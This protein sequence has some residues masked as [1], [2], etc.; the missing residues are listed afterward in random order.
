[1]ILLYH[2]VHPTMK[3]EWW[4]T[5]DTFYR[6]MLDLQDKRVVY[7]D[8]YDPRDPSQAVIT[9][10]GV[11][12]NVLEYAVP[13]MEKFGYP[14]ELFV[15]GDY[16]GRDNAF[17]S[18]EPLADFA[19][20]EELA[21][22][23]RRGGRIQWHTRS[24]PRV[25]QVLDLD[26]LRHE[27]E[28][29]PEVGALD[30]NGCRWFA[31]PHGEFSAEAVSLVRE[32]F[33]GALSCIQGDDSDIYQWNRL[34]VKEPTKITTRRISVIIPSYNYGPFLAEAVESVLRQT[35]SVDEIL[36]SDDASTDNTF[37]IA[38]HFQEQHPD[39]IRLNRNEKNL[40]IVDHFNRAVSLTSGDYITFLGAD[41][42]FRSDY[43]EHSCRALD[44]NPRAG[45]A[46]TDLCLFGSRASQVFSEFSR[47]FAGH[48]LLEKLFVVSF[49][50]FDEAARQLL[51]SGRNFIH[52]SSL[53]RRRAFE[54]VGGY[55]K[56]DDG[57]ED[58]GLFR[59]MIAA[60]WH[61]V[62]VAHPV[63]EYRQH[64]REQTNAALNSYLEL[65]YY[66]KKSQRLQD[67]VTQ[68]DEKLARLEKK[69]E[70]A[71]QKLKRAEDELR[72]IKRSVAWKLSKPARLVEGI[73]RQ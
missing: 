5:V 45:V 72:R 61:A 16:I 51:L 55:E 56:R 70:K 47:H 27:L 62:R 35:R 69:I 33:V 8:D 34:T 40:G 44:R 65:Q 19:S 60:D 52:G 14:F 24:H 50:D 29:P 59:R 15:T 66:K 2:K 31:Y 18:P 17:D 38:S 4:V 41:N 28:V 53:F 73:F 36:I 20:L 11:Y 71:E 7:L 46:Y 3:S 43:I 64:S 49:P 37:E 63:L 12:K 22:M 67:S 13:I 6:Q 68:R 54:E 21:E 39:L 42:R 23:V 10:D 9:F 1:M 25:N 26:C 30:A 32:R 48:V 57:P 58:F